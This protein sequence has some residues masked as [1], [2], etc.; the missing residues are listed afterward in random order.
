M[1][2]TG[3]YRAMILSARSSCFPMKPARKRS[4]KT[5][6]RLTSIKIFE[7]STTVRLGVNP[8]DSLEMM[9]E[10]AKR[11]I[12]R[13][14]TAR[15]NN[16]MMLSFLTFDRSASEREKTIIAITHSSRILKMIS[17]SRFCDRLIPETKMATR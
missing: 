10:R 7:T 11:S 3:R 5:S 9:A 12:N 13:V 16:R 17:K 1:K 2:Y 6:S 14:T 8:S 4:G 15:R